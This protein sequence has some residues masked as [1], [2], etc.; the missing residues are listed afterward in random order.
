MKLLEKTKHRLEKRKKRINAKLKTATIQHQVRIFRSNKHFYAQI[1]DVK[2]GTVVSGVASTKKGFS[3]SKNSNSRASCEK[4]AK[5]LGAKLKEKGISEIVFNR[6]GFK[7]HGKIKSFAD[8]LR[9]EGIK[10]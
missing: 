1:Y 6:A 8:A 7:Y 2:T 5:E 4:L 9:A 3:E 10:F